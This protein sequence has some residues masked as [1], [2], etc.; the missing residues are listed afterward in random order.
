M[1]WMTSATTWGTGLNSGDE[2]TSTERLLGSPRWASGVRG[3]YEMVKR[4]RT[5]ITCGLR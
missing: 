5:S 1:A 2:L 3:I 4:C